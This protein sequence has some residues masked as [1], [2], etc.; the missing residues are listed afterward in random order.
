ME[1]PELDGDALAEVPDEVGRVAEGTGG[2]KL[3]EVVFEGVVGVATT[4]VDTDEEE[5]EEKEL[6]SSARAYG[7]RRTRNESLEN[8]GAIPN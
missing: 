4:D 3:A 7:T 5:R 2:V 8:V 6:P 1:E